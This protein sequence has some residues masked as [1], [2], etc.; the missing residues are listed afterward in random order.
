MTVLLLGVMVR[1]QSVNG[2]PF[3]GLRSG[4]G[5]NCCYAVGTWHH[6]SP[7][8]SSTVGTIAHKP[9]A[10]QYVAKVGTLTDCIDCLVTLLAPKPQARPWPVFCLSE[11]T[12][13]CHASC[14]LKSKWK[15]LALSLSESL[16]CVLLYLVRFS[17]GSGHLPI[18]L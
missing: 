7:Q 1:L 5:L 4:L 16:L 10:S 13:L 2:Q 8:A 9:R 14:C 6:S 15:G 11:H 3:R 17:G 18:L 12:A